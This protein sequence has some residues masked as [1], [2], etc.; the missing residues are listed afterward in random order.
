MC[1]GVVNEL[2]EKEREDCNYELTSVVQAYIQ[3]SIQWTTKT[4]KPSI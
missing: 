1:R 3:E 2:K 4:R